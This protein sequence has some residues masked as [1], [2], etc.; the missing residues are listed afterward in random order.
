MN[1]SIKLALSF[2]FIILISLVS[3]TLKTRKQSPQ[4]SGES[5]YSSFIE[6]YEKDITTTIGE[7][8]EIPLS[9]LNQGNATWV[10][11][12]EYPYYLSYHL[13]DK[14]GLVLRFDNRRFSLPK[15]IYPGQ[16]ID[17]TIP[18]RS[19][20]EH[21]EYLLEFDLLR[22]GLFWFKD[23]GSLTS[24][25]K[26]S[27]KSKKWPEEEYT[28]GPDQKKYTKYWSS[29]KE[30][31]TILDLIRLTLEKNAVE[32]EGK[33]GKIR[34]FSAGSEYPQIW[35][36]D[37]NSAIGVAKYFYNAAYLE[38]FLEEMLAH[39]DPDGS[40]YD[41]IDS[42]G[43]TDK[44]TTETDQEASAI[45]IAFQIYEMRDI[46]WLKNVI[47]EYKIIDRLERALAYVFR[48]RYNPNYGLIIGAHT[49]D[50][51][52]VDMVDHTRD[53]VYVDD[54]THWTAD[55]YDQ[56]MVYRAC[57]CLSE[58]F[59]SLGRREKA[60]YWEE[61]AK[62]LK[63]QANQWLWQPDRGYFKVHIHLD[64]LQHLFEEDNILA[65]GGNTQAILSGLTDDEQTRRIF[66]NVLERQNSLKIS[67]IS[68][69]LLPPYPK[70]T[71]K[72]PLIDDPFEYQNG[73]QWDWFGGRFIY[74]LFENGMSTLAYEK[75]REIFQKNISNKGLLEWDNREGVGFGSDYFLG[76]AGSLGRA[77][78]E[79]YFGI[80]KRAGVLSIE[81]KLKQDSAK[82]QV[83]IP[84]QDIF[85]AY[86]YS[87]DSKNNSIVLKYNSNYSQNGTIKIL[88]PWS[89]LRGGQPQVKSL[90]TVLLDG[91]K[92]AF[93]FEKINEDV[94]IV[95]DTNFNDHKA[96]ILFFPNS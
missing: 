41:W 23:H 9:I 40:L 4:F 63:T 5:E 28:R 1:R 47:D 51:G 56:S 89:Q 87:F 60:L 67:T 93:H 8:V 16:K 18:L 59:S 69:T 82:I 29:Y 48:E 54:R 34:G 27:V 17:M 44:N 13:L 20:L 61:K 11:V 70:R 65:M 66:K 58:M 84:A 95:F 30:L 53:A 31:N 38:S 32:F 26:L 43:R 85:V 14:N 64:D 79:G 86:D 73:A 7:R 37:S 24:E 75:M 90:H 36:R 81:P 39:Q 77:I 49:A 92:K 50:W 46:H 2:F 83:Y 78:F 74:A 71:F 62:S 72:H 91:D 6:P 25:I 12:G 21:G 96:E 19:P 57:L 52:D 80:K 15:R 76:S 68:G 35:I 45:Q 42:D 55:I 10:P 3:Y 88:S 22:E 94:F 33:T